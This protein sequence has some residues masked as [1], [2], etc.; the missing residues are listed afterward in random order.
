MRSAWAQCRKEYDTPPSH[1]MHPHP[2]TM[3]HATFERHSSQS[4]D[5]HGLFHWRLGCEYRVRPSVEHL[6]TT[7]HR[8]RRIDRL[9]MNQLTSGPCFGSSPPAAELWEATSSG[10]AVRAAAAA[11]LRVRG[12]RGAA[13][14]GS[15]VDRKPSPCVTVLAITTKSNSMHCWS[16]RLTSITKREDV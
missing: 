10:G 6:C 5:H 15:P 8:S 4:T 9:A 7:R 12:L 3:G 2:Q 16:P 14:F 1:S 13:T 11:R